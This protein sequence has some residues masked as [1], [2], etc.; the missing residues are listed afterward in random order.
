M[1]AVQL[2]AL[3]VGGGAGTVAR[4]LV[5]HAVNG[6]RGWNTA[7]FPWHT[8]AIN[9]AGSF[10]LGII[11][12]ALKDRPDWRLFLGTGFCGGFTTFSTFSIETVE[13]F[14]RDETAAGLYVVGSVAAGVMGAVLGMKM[15]G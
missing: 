5:G 1:T 12:V 10:F 7:T 8:F 9:V 15:A 2:A 4:F 6:G 11:A 14:K 3:V 13:L